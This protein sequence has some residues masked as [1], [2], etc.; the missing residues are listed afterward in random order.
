M[1]DPRPAV[2][3]V[4][5]NGDKVTV[6]FSDGHSAIFE[7]FRDEEYERELEGLKHFSLFYEE[8]QVVQYDGRIFY[9]GPSEN[10]HRFTQVAEGYKYQRIA[11]YWQAAWGYVNQRHTREARRVS[12]GYAAPWKVLYGGLKDLE[13]I[14]SGMA[15]LPELEPDEN[16]LEPI[17]PQGAPPLP[18]GESKVP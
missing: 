15:R 4:V 7:G 18:R 9:S 16:E 12:S 8:E 14:K 17:M 1:V 11:S 5:T 13:K 2:K 6:V 3:S 10:Q